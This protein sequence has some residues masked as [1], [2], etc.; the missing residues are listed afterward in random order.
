MTVAQKDL[1]MWDK[2]PVVQIFLGILGFGLS[3]MFCTTFCRLCQ[4]FRERQVDREEWRRNAEEG[5]TPPIY[6]IPF[7][8]SM[9]QQDSEDHSRVPSYSPEILYG[10]SQYNTNPYCGPPPSYNEVGQRAGTCLLTRISVVCKHMW[11]LAM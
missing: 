1:K 6:V 2:V 4:H 8:R 5:R 9:S 11:I 3:I 10:P 7:P